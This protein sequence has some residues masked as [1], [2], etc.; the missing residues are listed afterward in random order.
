M[1]PEDSAK[2]SLVAHP[3]I[4]CN[5]DEGP[6]GCLHQSLGEIQPPSS[7]VLRWRYAYACLKGS[8]EVAQAQVDEFCEVLC[9][10]RVAQ[11]VVDIGG[12]PFNLPRG[13]AAASTIVRGSYDPR[14][15]QRGCAQEVFPRSCSIDVEGSSGAFDQTDHGRT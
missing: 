3:A 7:N 6:I 14:P 9:L 1:A 13:E 2:L 5:L 15:E 4:K 8:E 12:H 11:F 10:D